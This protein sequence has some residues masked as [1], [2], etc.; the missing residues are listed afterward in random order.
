MVFTAGGSDTDITLTPNGSGTVVA[1]ASVLPSADSSHDLGS[2]SVRWA[3]VWSDNVTATGGTITG[4]TD[5][6]VADGGTGTS[7]GS[8]TG[9][10]ALAFTAGGTAQNVSLAPSTTGVIRLDGGVVINEDSADIDFRIES[11]A[12]EN[13]VVVDGGA[14]TMAIGGA[15]TANGHLLAGTDSA[16]DIGSTGTRWLNVWTDNITATGGTITGITDLAVADGGTGTSSGSIT[17]TGAL[18]FTAGGT[19]TDITLTPNG[20]G[21]VIVSANLLPSADST[22][23]LGVTGTRWASIWTD[24]ITATGGTITGI[25]DLAVADGGTGTSTGSIT[26][27][28]ALTFTAGGSVQNVSLVPS[29]TGVIRLDGGVV[30]NE[31]S[32][33]VDFRIES[34]DNDQALVVDGG[35]N[36]VCIGNAVQE[37]WY[38]LYSPLQIGGTSA[39]SSLTTTAGAGPLVLHQNSYYAPGP[40]MR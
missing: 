38:S 9:T 29:T 6:A 40:L 39:I 7:T 35:T 17:G 34:N 15:I 8:I 30:V 26:G 4:I 1:S 36:V 18:V 28:G 24:S 21:S 31:D 11:D 27:T 5:L 33:D 14:S 23:S 25:T 37:T 13:M 20:S 19:D 16:Y 32:A 22:L 3:N 2:T 10:G 12:N